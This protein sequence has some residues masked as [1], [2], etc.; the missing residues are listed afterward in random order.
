[1]SASSAPS[2]LRCLQRAMM[3][4]WYHLGAVHSPIHL[5]AAT[6]MTGSRTPRYPVPAIPSLPAAATMMTFLLIVYLVPTH[7]R[8]RVSLNKGF[9]KNSYKV[10]YAKLV[11]FHCYVCWASEQFRTTFNLKK[12]LRNIKKFPQSENSEIASRHK[13]FCIVSSN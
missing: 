10:H 13:S 11:Q 2:A 9:P 4:C 5:D 7:G 1:M 6:E 12:S 8:E 3:P